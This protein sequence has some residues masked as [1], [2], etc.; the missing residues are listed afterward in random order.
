MNILIVE[1][2]VFF[3]DTLKRQLR[4]WGHDATGAETGRAGLRKAESMQFD[5]VLLDVFL[6]DMTAM[7]LIPQLRRGRSDAP[8]VTLTGQNT[9]ELERT[10]RELGIAY[11]M[12]KPVTASELHAVI[13]HMS[14][15]TQA[16]PAAPGR[17][18]SHSACRE[19]NP[20]A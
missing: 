11:Y 10:L 20:G 9:R 19:A 7:D 12:A 15:L 6:P 4:G 16:S 14:R 13:D 18:C 17:A 2:D 3:M 5:L 8:I 1:D